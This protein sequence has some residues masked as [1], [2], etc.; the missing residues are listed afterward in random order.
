MAC[1]STSSDNWFPINL[2]YEFFKSVYLGI[3]EA[4]ISQLG[5]WFNYIDLKKQASKQT[6]TYFTHEEWK[7]SWQDLLLLTCGFTATNRHQSSSSQHS[8]GVCCNFSQRVTAPA[9]RNGV[10]T[11]LMK[12][13]LC[14]FIYST[15]QYI[16]NVVVSVVNHCSLA[17]NLLEAYMCNKQI[18][19]SRDVDLTFPMAT[20]EVAMSKTKLSPS[21]AGAATLMGLVPKVHCRVHKVWIMKILWSN[22]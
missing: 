21:L 9:L 3:D 13:H 2:L 14:T 17:F 18:C 1:N 16:K 7:H 15:V 20:A 5:L 8:L 22:S 4:Q 12:L 19:S 10:S 11:P 6:N